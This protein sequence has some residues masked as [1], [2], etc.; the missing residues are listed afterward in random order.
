MLFQNV[1]NLRTQD[2]GVGFKPFFD[3]HTSRLKD[4][5]VQAAKVNP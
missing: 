2:V 3:G 5:W 4:D 1:F